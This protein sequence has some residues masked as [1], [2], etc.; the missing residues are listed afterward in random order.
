MADRPAASSLSN[1]SRVV[2]VTAQQ[3]EL[4]ARDDREEPVTVVLDR[5][6]SCSQSSPSGG[7]AQSET[8]QRGSSSSCHFGGLATA[9]ADHQ[10][11]GSRATT[12][13]A[14]TL[15]PPGARSADVVSPH[16]QRSHRTEGGGVLCH[17][18]ARGPQRP[19]SRTRCVVQ[20]G[21]L[22]Q[23][24]VGEGDTSC[25]YRCKKR[26]GRYTIDRSGS[27]KHYAAFGRPS[28]R[29]RDALQLC[30]WRRFRRQ[31]CLKPP[32]EL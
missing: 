3:P 16:W 14:R 20:V 18:Y 8:I 12:W 6:I 23:I 13:P 22:A 28:G 24:A 5:L 17:C 2:A 10:M 11:I 29:Y 15:R 25:N 1:G 27:P 31:S 30:R 21:V 32:F 4:A 19:V 9:Y 7:W 26:Q